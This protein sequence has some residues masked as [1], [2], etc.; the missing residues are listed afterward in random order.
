METVRRL[1]NEPAARVAFFEKQK[2]NI[3]MYTIAFAFVLFV[4]HIFS[5][6][7]FSFLLTLGSMVRMFGFVLLMIKFHHERTSSGISLKTLELY[8]LVFVSRLCSILFYEGYL[9]YDSSGDWL[10]QL[11]EV[12]SLL[13]CVAAIV[14]V[15]F[16]SETYVPS[17]DGFGNFKY[18]PSQLGPVVLVIPC[19]ILALIFHPTLNKNK[20]TDTAWTFAAYLETVS[21]LPQVHSF[22]HFAKFYSILKSQPIAVS[23]AQ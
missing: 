12:T 3:I 18:I 5:D 20:F 16:F 22:I 2:L 8:S 11:V 19:L 7:D 10:Y 14:Y 23:I 4:Y 9:P 1:M 6:G 21:V 17:E 15:L 13:L